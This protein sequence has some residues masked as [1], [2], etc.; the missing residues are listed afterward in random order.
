LNKD[1]R[2]RS[3][4]IDHFA[5]AIMQGGKVYWAVPIM[6]LIERR[7]AKKRHRSACLL[8]KRKDIGR[9]VENDN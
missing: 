3:R 5:F 4:N 2:A 1:L 9:H 8:E 7:A 6:V